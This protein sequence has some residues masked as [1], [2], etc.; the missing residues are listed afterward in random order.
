M[1]VLVGA[2]RFWAD[3][4]GGWIR[5]EAG[6]G[7]QQ[8]SASADGGIRDSVSEAGRNGVL[9][10]ALRAGGR[11]CRAGVSTKR[12]G[13]SR[14]VPRRIIAESPNGHPQIVRPDSGEAAAEHATSRAG[15]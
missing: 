11:D 10:R 5:G 13:E 15:E 7:G 4:P 12:A 9:L 2:A 6:E 3:A 1:K 8:A 14:G